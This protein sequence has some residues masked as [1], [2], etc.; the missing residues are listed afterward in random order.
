MTT[1]PRYFLGLL[2]AVSL[3]SFAAD[4]KLTVKPDNGQVSLKWTP[5]PDAK[6]YS[7]CMAKEPIVDI[8]QCTL[9]Q[10]G[11]QTYFTGNAY[12]IAGLSNDST[13]SFRVL[14]RNHD[15]EQLAVSNAITVKLGGMIPKLAT[16]TPFSKISAKG[17]VLAANAKSWACVR[18][19]KTHLTWEVKTTDGGLRDM[20]KTY[21]NFGT[22]D[23]ADTGG[24]VKAVNQQGLCGKK[25]WR[26]PTREELQSIV[27]YGRYSPAIDETYFPYAQRD[28]YWS[29][30]LYVGDPSYTWHVSFY[31]GVVNYNYPYGANAVRL[32]RG[33]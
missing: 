16:K 17:Q 28:Y 12:V 18:D 14:A 11:Q 27:D 15:S 31:D 20:D 30:S 32:V 8:D 23:A 25:D 4:F 19:N 10:D 21:T 5:V 22:I 24:F 33:G 26:L 2:A 9:Y 7:L 6:A 1:T 13:Y 3:N 29:S